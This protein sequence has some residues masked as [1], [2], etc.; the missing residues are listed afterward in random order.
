MNTKICPE[1]KQDKLITEFGKNENYKDGYEKICKECKNRRA[2][3]RYHSDPEVKARKA[4]YRKMYLS[5]PEKH[6]EQIE[7]QRKWRNSNIENQ[8]FREKERERCRKYDQSPRGR[9]VRKLFQSSEKSK[10]YHKKYAQEKG[11]PRAKERYHNDPEF[12]KRM[13]ASAKKWYYSE[14][15]IVSRTSKRRKEW[16]SEYQKRNRIH[17]REYDRNKYNTDHEYYARVREKN[18]TRIERERTNGGNFT[19]HDWKFLKELADG[20]CLCCGKKGKLTMDHII[21]VSQNGSTEI[22]NIQPLCNSCNAKKGKNTTD[23]RNENFKMC[24]INYMRGEN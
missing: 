24:V 2:R 9:E 22:D 11:I 1:C 3:E 20:K 18:N 5:D 21:P 4:E 17:F 6:S 7:R 12:R 15:G 10:E 8:E 23:Y 13:R 19:R 16:Q 14:K